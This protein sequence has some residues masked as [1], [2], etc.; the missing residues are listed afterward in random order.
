MLELQ[1]VRAAKMRGQEPFLDDERQEEDVEGGED[2]GEGGD[3]VTRGQAWCLYL[4]HF[5]S[6]WNSR[7][8]EFGAVSF[9][10]REASWFLAMRVLCWA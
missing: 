2:E 8:Y 7:M 9:S 5:L 4:S 1:D 6:M 10:A 3:E